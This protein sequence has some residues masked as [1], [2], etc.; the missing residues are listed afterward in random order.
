MGARHDFEEIGRT[1]DRRNAS[2]HLDRSCDRISVH[3]S[4]S[5]HDDV[6][7]MGFIVNFLY[8]GWFYTNKGATPGKMVM[9]LRVVDHETGTNISW[10]AAI[11]RQIGQWFDWILLIGVLMACF[12]RDKRALHDF[13]AGSQVLQK[14]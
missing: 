8:Y 7:G 2:Q 4:P 10:G 11:L 5:S 6:L 1:S 3:G 9:G 13:M 14:R 12:R